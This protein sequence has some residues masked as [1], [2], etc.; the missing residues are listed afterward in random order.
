MNIS[1]E[2]TCSLLETAKNVVIT[3]HVNPDGDAIGSSIGL[4]TFL[5]E[6]GK[7]VKIVI[8]DKL[9]RNLSFLHGYDRIQRSGDAEAFKDVDLLVILDTDMSRIGNLNELAKNAKTLN[10]DHHISND[11]KAD[12]LYLAKSSATAEIIFDVIS[13][14]KA[15][16][17]ADVAMALYTGIATDTGFFKYSNTRSSTMMAGAKLIEAGA[18]PNVVSEAIEEKPLEI[19]KGQIEALST[20]EITSNGRVAGM[21]L[22]YPLTS[23]LESTEGFIDLIR[24]IEGVEVAVF[25]KSVEEKVCRVSMRSKGFD[26]S[27]IAMKLGGGG[28]IRAA[29]CTLYMPLQEAKTTVLKEISDALESAK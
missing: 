1:L 28:H 14:M 11:Q 5:E 20:L 8:C 24:V 10:I 4:G 21:F 7:N 3:A 23:S 16:I 17:S 12:Y 22:D 29:G 25:V 18:S 15:P 9:P 2:K 27:K 26:V 13:Y 19:V 6:Q